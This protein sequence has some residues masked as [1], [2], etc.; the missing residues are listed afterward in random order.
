MY[1]I[2]EEEINAVARVI[3]SGNMFKIND[4]LQEVKHFEEELKDKYGTENA[5]LMTSGKAALISALVG[6]GIGPG[7]QVI[8]PA[9]TYIATAIAVTAVGAIPVIAEVDETLTIDPADVEKKLTPNTKAVIP[10]HIQGF[11]CNLDAICALAEKHGLAVIEDACQSVGGDYRGKKL[12]TVGNAGALSF[13]QF[14]VISAG[15]AGALM[16]N[17]R[18]VFSR[19]LIHHDSSAIAYFGNQLDG[20]EEEQFCGSEFRSNEITAAILREQLKRLDGIIADLRKNRRKIIGGLKDIFDFIPSNDDAGDCG[21]TVAFRFENEE[22]TRKFAQLSPVGLCIP[23]DTGK[24]VYSN[25]TAVMNKRGAFHEGMDPFRMEANRG[26]VPDYNADM[27]PKMLDL[28]KRT[29]YLSVSPDWDDAQ[30]TDIIN[31]FKTAAEKL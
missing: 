23:I 11:P 29:A 7:D 27:C 2:G 17:D 5:I 16:T 20:N 8:I 12:G 26:L 28:L 25:W 3:R 14:K 4:G 21:T 6:L 31:G 10:V 9:Y 30:I 22:K 18:T 24:H 1:R 15:E 13:N 19:A